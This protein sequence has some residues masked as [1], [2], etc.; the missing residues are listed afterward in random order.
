MFVNR[1]FSFIC[2]PVLIFVLS[3]GVSACQ[4]E[5]QSNSDI[6]QPNDLR[7][8]KK[9]VIQARDILLVTISP[10]TPHIV[11]GS[12]YSI[13]AEIRNVSGEKVSV[14]LNSIQLVVQAELAPED[15]GCAWFYSA[16]Y[17]SAIKDNEA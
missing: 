15:N 1:K 7:V 16:S 3:I 13:D 2:L 6:P 9:S 8:V 11:R 12:V 17:I 5:S 10:S 14:D 4:A